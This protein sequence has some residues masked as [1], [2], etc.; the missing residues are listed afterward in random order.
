MF[1][2]DSNGRKARIARSRMREDKVVELTRRG[3]GSR[4]IAKEMGIRQDTVCHLWKRA[5]SRPSY[6]EAERR[7]VV[8]DQLNEQ[9]R[10]W[11][12]FFGREV[13]KAQKAEEDPQAMPAAPVFAKIMA[14][15][16][17]VYQTTIT[18]HGL[19][20]PIK[21]DALTQEQLGKFIERFSQ[22][23]PPEMMEVALRGALGERS[24]EAPPGSRTPEGG[25]STH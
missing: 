8:D 4:D 17:S 7:A 21:V 5:T 23:I 6:N 12:A 1:E 24:K 2:T 11:R 3:F 25:Q 20:Q 13:K 19:A 18:L 15:M 14:G 9:I 10:Y 16:L 22:F